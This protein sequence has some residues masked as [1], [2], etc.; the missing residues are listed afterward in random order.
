MTQPC[1]RPSLG[2]G[3]NMLDLELMHNYTTSTY[4][5]LSLDTYLRS[6]WRDPTVQIGLECDYV[7]KSILA[8]SALHL[9]RHQ[10]AQ[11]D[12]YIDTALAY[13]QIASRKAFELLSDEDITFKNARNLFLFSSLTVF[14]G[15]SLP[16]QTLAAACDHPF[17]T[18]HSPRRASRTADWC[19]SSGGDQLPQLGIFAPRLQIP[20]PPRK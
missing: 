15:R 12:Y 3:L 1:P 10:P 5:T 4:A 7:M 8:V 16:C 13:H 11:K 2:L 18:Q 19:T 6:V 9:A 14:F 20:S 17:L